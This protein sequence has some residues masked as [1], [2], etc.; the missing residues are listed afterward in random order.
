WLRRAGSH[1]RKRL[2]WRSTRAGRSSPP[3]GSERGLHRVFLRFY[4]SPCEYCLP[5]GD[6]LQQRY[7]NRQTIRDEYFDWALV[8]DADYVVATVAPSGSL[9]MLVTDQRGKPML[10]FDAHGNRTSYIP[11]AFD[12]TRSILDAAGNFTAIVSDDFGRTTTLRDP[13]RGDNTFTYN[14]FGET[15]SHTDGNG[16]LK[17]YFYDDL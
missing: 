15:T 13:A 17:E 1:C 4:R 6:T 14:A 11:G 9:D 10:S 5:H 2:L 8:E 7:A 3:G 16:A 12:V